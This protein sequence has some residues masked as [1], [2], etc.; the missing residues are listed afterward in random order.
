MIYTCF[1]LIR[2]INGKLSILTFNDRES[3]TKFALNC[4][5]VIL[6]EGCRIEGNIS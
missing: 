3:A 1:Y 4:D 2:L 5:S 6:I